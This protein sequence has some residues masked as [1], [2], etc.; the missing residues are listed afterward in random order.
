MSVSVR[1]ALAV[2]APLAVI[3]CCIAA[4]AM[5]DAVDDA[6]PL[7]T[8][9]LS[10]FPST[11]GSGVP[12]SIQGM[13]SSFAP[14]NEA[15]DGHYGAGK[16]VTR[17]EAEC[18]W[19]PSSSNFKNADCIKSRM[20]QFNSRHPLTPLLYVDP[21]DVHIVVPTIRD[22]DFLDKWKNGRCSTVLTLSW[23][24]TAILTSA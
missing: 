9:D 3:A 19:D 15:A 12:A 21:A 2:I 22:L 14:I 4:V 11:T 16:A 8:H 17:L 7:H 20:P 13:L 6:K 18:G 24:R 5:A 23:C 10:S 1:L